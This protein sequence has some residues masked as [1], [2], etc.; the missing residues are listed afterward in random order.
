MGTTESML[1]KYKL[2]YETTPSGDELIAEAI[3]HQWLRNYQ[4]V[5]LLLNKAGLL[6]LTKFRRVK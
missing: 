5:V 3:E 6:Q 2:F 4:K 1:S